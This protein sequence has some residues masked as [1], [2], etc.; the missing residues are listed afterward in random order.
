MRV[1]LTSDLMKY[2][3][4]LP[5]A[6]ASAVL[7]IKGTRGGGLMDGAPDRYFAMAR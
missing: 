2:E 6:G 4:A 3:T 7:C 5:Q 1:T